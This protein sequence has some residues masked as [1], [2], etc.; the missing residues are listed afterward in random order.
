MTS[1]VSRRTL[2]KGLAWAAPA[3][4]AS[5]NVPAYAASTKPEYELSLSWLATDWYASNGCYSGTVHYD[6]F[7]FDTA[8]SVD[9]RPAGFA[10]QAWDYDSPITT[11]TLGRFELKVAFPVGPIKSIA[12]TGGAYTVS[13]PVRQTVNGVLTDVYTFTYTGVRTAQTIPKG[14]SEPSWPDSILRTRVTI[15]RYSCYQI[16]RT[17]YVQFSESFMT[18]NGYSE[19]F[20]SKW[21]SNTVEPRY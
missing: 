2:A 17:Y 19:S 3:V 11:A 4:V 14:A 8:M 5:A 1:E 13:G 9:G 20:T 6:Y 7:T 15:D 12:V 21:L 10:V 18:A 16:M